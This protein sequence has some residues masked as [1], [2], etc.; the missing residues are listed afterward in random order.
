[1]L[2]LAKHV[3][4]WSKDP[5][6]QVGAVVMREDRTVASLGYNG[7]PRGVRDAEQRYAD[8][9]LKYA[10]VVHA[11]ANAIL[12]AHEPLKGM[13]IFTYPFPP[14]SNCAGM[15]IQSGIK[16]IIA[17]A[18]T[19]EQRERWGTNMSIAE[20]MFHEAGVELVLEES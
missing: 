20:A 17:P 1:M 14:C 8:R 19:E 11:E 12:H 13:T 5:S 10:M 9:E 15:I 4:S 6:T 3:A 2:D 18:P 16:R 7:F